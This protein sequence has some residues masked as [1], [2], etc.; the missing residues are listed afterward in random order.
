MRW[1][2]C[3]DGLVLMEDW[4]TGCIAWLE[5]GVAGVGIVYSTYQLYSTDRLNKIK[6]LIDHR[7]VEGFLR[8]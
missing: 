3:D 1:A 5:Y 7:K 8:L 2:L 6:E 4:V